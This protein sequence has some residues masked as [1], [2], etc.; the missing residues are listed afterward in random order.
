MSIEDRIVYIQYNV[1]KLE[2]II[3]DGTSRKLHD[4]FCH[5]FFPTWHRGKHSL[6]IYSP[7]FSRSLKI[8]KTVTNDPPTAFFVVKDPSV[9]TGRKK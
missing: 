5:N 3:Q 7:C 2:E 4:Y 1:E 6:P 9:P 8:S